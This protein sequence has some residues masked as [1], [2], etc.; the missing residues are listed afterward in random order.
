MRGSFPG[1]EPYDELLRW[2]PDGLYVRGRGEDQV[3]LF[4]V[5]PDNGDRTPL[6]SPVLDKIEGFLGIGTTRIT[7]DGSVV[8]YNYRNALGELYLFEG[9]K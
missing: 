1:V 7:P 2:G 8:V 6:P 9:L 5:D 3:N 4:R